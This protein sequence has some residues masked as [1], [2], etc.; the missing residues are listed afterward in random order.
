MEP[1]DALAQLRPCGDSTEDG[2]RRVSVKISPESFVD[3]D[4]SEAG[5]EMTLTMSMAHPQVNFAAAVIAL[6]SEFTLAMANLST[7]AFGAVP[8]VG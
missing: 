1:I 3:V 2:H 4:V 5:V 7:A 6:Q 8:N